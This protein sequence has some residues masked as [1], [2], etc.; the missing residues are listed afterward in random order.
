MC[1]PYS[2]LA[3]LLLI[4]SAGAQLPKAPLFK[5]GDPVPEL[6]VAEW[7]RDEPFQGWDK[8][9]LSVVEFWAT[10]CVPCK[11]AMPHL[12]TLAKKY[13][14]DV[15]F[16][17]ISIQEQSQMIPDGVR[18]FVRENEAIMQ[19]SVGRDADGKPDSNCEMFYWF[20]GSKQRGI[21]VAYIVDRSGKLLWLG[22]PLDLDS[23]LASALAGKL[24]VAKERKK[25]ERYVEMMPRPTRFP[26]SSPRLKSGSNPDSG[27]R[28]STTS[29]WQRVE[30]R[31]LGTA[32]SA[33]KFEC[34]QFTTPAAATSI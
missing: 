2:F 15:G 22:H 18:A 26:R 31:T 23:P 9:K 32:R 5:P 14:D 4:T 24:D 6:K 34:S 13:S 8:H 28:P 30:I 3:F 19:Y 10:W 12:S 7:M 25:F 27:R 33:K 16:Y 29:T 21:P 11:E 17:S 1:K 20:M